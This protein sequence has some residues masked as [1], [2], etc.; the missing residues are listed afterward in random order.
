MSHFHY[1]CV[2]ILQFLIVGV[3]VN[4]NYNFF[5]CLKLF[6]QDKGNGTYYGTT[7]GLC[8]ILVKGLAPLQ[9][10]TPGKNLIF[11]HKIF[12]KKKI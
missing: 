11:F 7:A 2:E 5:V 1:F 9:K 6:F 4:E 3:P 10:S 12:S 8:Q